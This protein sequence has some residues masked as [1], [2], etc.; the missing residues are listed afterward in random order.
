MTRDHGFHRIPVAEV[1]AETA[2]AA[3][4]VLDVPDELSDAYA[5]RAGQ[6]CTFRAE[7]DGAAFLRCYSM[8]STPGVD[9]ALK[10]TVKRVPEGK[11]SNWLI[12]NVRAGTEL[13]VTLPAGVFTLDPDETE[14]VLFAA[15]SG[16]TPIISLA[17]QALHTTDRS[18]RMLYANRDGDSVIFADELESL[19][20]EFADRFEVVHHHDVDQGFVDAAEVDAFLGG[21]TAGTTHSGDAG[22]YL[23]GPTPFMDIVEGALLARGVPEARVHLERFTPAEDRVDV[24][25]PTT[26]DPAVDGTTVTIELDGTTRSGPH[27]PGATILQTARSFDLSP[28]YSCESGSCATCMGRLLEGTVEM[29]VNDALDDDEVEDGFILTCQSV[30]TSSTVHVRYGFD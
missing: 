16:I 9:P 24:V 3:S 18:V 26:D 15:G 14:L 25:D 6:F 30:P 22:H 27:H 8:S 12:D 11:V 29:H 7:V 19:A 13:D 2:D 5:Y 4:F 10:V 20:K 23:C 28:P 1:V 21:A 17:K